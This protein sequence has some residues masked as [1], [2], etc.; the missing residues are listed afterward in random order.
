MSAWGDR[1]GLPV[2]LKM[3]PEMVAF[4]EFEAAVCEECEKCAGCKGACKDGM[5]D[6]HVPCECEA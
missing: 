2:G 6:H 3:P 1:D 5:W 4:M